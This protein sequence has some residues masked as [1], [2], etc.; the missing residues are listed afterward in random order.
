M[1]VMTLT[2]NFKNKDFKSNRRTDPKMSSTAVLSS[3]VVGLIVGWW[4]K[5]SKVLSLIISA[6]TGG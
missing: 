4:Y 1:S 5:D 2:L 6:V 3:V